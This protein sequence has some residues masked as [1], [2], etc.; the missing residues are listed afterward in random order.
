[1][2]GDRV[3][4][5]LQRF[6]LIVRTSG[7]GQRF[8]LQVR[9]GRLTGQDEWYEAVLVGEYQGFVEEFCR[10]LQGKP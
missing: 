5:E 3:L 6:Q 7:S 9:S 2:T 8:L 1:M 10:T 4:L